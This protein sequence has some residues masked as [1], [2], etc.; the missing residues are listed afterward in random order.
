M[1]WDLHDKLSQALIERDVIANV[2]VVDAR[3][4]EQMQT[5]VRSLIY[6]ISA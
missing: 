2:T 5:L 1:P 3:C 4:R 6:M